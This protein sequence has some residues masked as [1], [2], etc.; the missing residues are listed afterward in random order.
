MVWYIKIWSL[1]NYIFN[2]MTALMSEIMSGIM[3][4]GLSIFCEYG[5][6]GYSINSKESLV[7]GVFFLDYR[8]NMII[9]SDLALKGNISIHLVKWHTTFHV[10]IEIVHTP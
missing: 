9:W 3:N 5:F 10:Y 4:D 1:F 8:N 2:K 6:Q 7:L